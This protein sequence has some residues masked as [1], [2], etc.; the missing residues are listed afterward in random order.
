MSVWLGAGMW[1]GVGMRL[2]GGTDAGAGV[3]VEVRWWRRG[4]GR[5]G[6]VGGA[7]ADV[8]IGV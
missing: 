6:R 1:L 5:C 4:A 2:G 7:G 3:D 8:D